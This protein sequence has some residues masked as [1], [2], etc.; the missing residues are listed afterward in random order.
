MAVKM[1]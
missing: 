1:A